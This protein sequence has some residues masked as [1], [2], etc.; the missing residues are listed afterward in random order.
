MSP[1]HTATDEQRKEIK[2]LVEEMRDSGATKEEIMEAIGL[3]LEEWG[4][5]LPEK[6]VLPDQ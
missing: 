3:K 1:I 5:E 4:I 6:P 2:E